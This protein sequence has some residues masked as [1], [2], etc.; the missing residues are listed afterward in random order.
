MTINNN[1]TDREHLEYLVWLALNDEPIITFSFG[2]V[3]LGFP[4]MQMRTWLNTYN[5]IN[6][7]E[8][9]R[10]EEITRFKINKKINKE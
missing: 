1:L 8:N 10:K 3:L 6:A 7:L 2:A 9:I 4:I 5:P